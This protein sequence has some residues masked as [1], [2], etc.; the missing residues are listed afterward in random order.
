MGGGNAVSP[1]AVLMDDHR[2]DGLGVGRY[3]DAILG[4]GEFVAG[5]RLDGRLV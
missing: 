3:P 4:R 2:A 5:A 1:A